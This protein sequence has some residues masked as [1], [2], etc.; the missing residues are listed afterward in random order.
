VALL[1]NRSADV[2]SN[3]VQGAGTQ[4]AV[5]TM[6][7]N[8]A[9]KVE[10]VVA[11]VSNGSA[12]DV[13]PELTI[14]DSSGVVIA[15]RRQTAPIPAGDTGTATFALRLA[16]DG[17]ASAAGFVPTLAN[18]L[19]LY[20]GQFAADATTQPF[21][22]GWADGAV[23]LDVSTPTDPLVLVSGIYAINTQI[24]QGAAGGSAAVRAQI[25]MEMSDP[26]A[27]IPTSWTEKPTATDAWLFQRFTTVA[28]FDSAVP[29]RL[30]INYPLIAAPN[31]VRHDTRVQRIT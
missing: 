19:G 23:L 31:T 15:T 12:S 22:W 7:S 4:S 18:S 2:S 30:T 11:T 9:L 17:G 21:P 1:A 29:F 28:F 14:K 5:F 6:P 13:T 27:Q 3:L 20:S 25:A 26:F 10:S 8:V 16:D 24:D